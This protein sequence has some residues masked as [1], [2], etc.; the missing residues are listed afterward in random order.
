MIPPADAPPSVGLRESRRRQNDFTRALL[1]KGWYHSFELPDG[2]RIDGCMPLEWERAR[3]T[4]FPL[5]A[6]LTGKR[7]LDIGAWDGW[8]SF[9]AERRGAAVTSVDVFECA[10]YLNMHRRL[11]SRADY[12]NL[13]L[14]EIPTAGLGRFEIV[15]FLGVLYHLKY[16]FLGL[17]IVCGLTTDVAI[18]ESFV[19]DGPTWRGDR[20]DIPRL[21]FYETDEL[22]GQFDNWFGPSVGALEALCRA[23]GFARVENL[24]VDRDSA[25]LACYRHWLPEPVSPACDP[26]ELLALANVNTYGINFNSRRDQYVA[27]WF[28]TAVP[29]LRR[30]RLHL[31]I[32][33]FGAPAVH[34]Q[35]EET[36]AWR[37]TFRIPP[38]TPAGWSDVR[39]RLTESCF[40]ATRRIAIDML[41]HVEAIALKDVL[42]AHTW[43]PR[44]ITSGHATCWV[45]GLPENCDAHNVRAFLG[46]SRAAVSFIGEPGIDG[47]RQVNTALAPDTPRGEKPFRIECGGVSSPPLT[48]RID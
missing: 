5:P 15:F 24:A 27:C 48:V 38:G 43:T 35:L 8:F 13:D 6:D 37:G 11:G 32:G 45:S 9:E 36:G 10:N 7:V 40:G 25:L 47:F 31:E 42:D 28:R 34:L 33:G 41:L 26:P 2:T 23:A 17:E 22:N 12:R 4:R 3:W 18:V 29:D 1:E 39:L 20:N 16:P 44:R 14:Y 46:E 21:E 30:E 19:I